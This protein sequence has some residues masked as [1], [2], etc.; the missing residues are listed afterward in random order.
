MCRQFLIGA[1]TLAIT[2]CGSGGQE[3]AVGTP[4]PSGADPTRIFAVQGNGPASPLVGQSVTVQGIVTGDFQDGD[5]DTTRDLGGFYMQDAPDG[6]FATSD[7]IFVFDGSNPPVD[8][9]AGDVVRVTGT[10]NEYYGETQIS[11]GNVTIVGT[12]SLLPVS[13][14]LPA[15][16]TVSNADGQLVADLER[17]EGMLVQFPQTLSVASLYSL[18]RDGDVLLSLDGVP[19]SFTNGNAPDV[20]GYA[21]HRSSIAARRVILD[22]G[23][24]AA[25]V[26]PVRYLGAG[27]TTGYSIRL[28]DQLSNARGVLR[29]SRGSGASGTEGYRLMP[30]ADLAF[31][32]VNPLPAAPEPGGTLRIAALNVLNLFSKLDDG[33]DQCGPDANQACR[34]ANSAAEL[35][36]QLARLVTAITLMEPDIIGVIEIENNANG[37]LD[38]LVSAL[39]ASLAPGTYAYVETGPIGTDAIKV[40][41][42]YRPSRVSPVGSPAIL[43]SAVDVRFDDRRNRPVLAQTFAQVSDDARLTVAI[44]HLKSKSSS[45]ASDGDP[46]IGDG[47]GNCNL[48]RTEAARAL[49]AW[50]AADPTGSGDPDTLLIGD[51]NAYVFEDP[52]AVLEAA[53]FVNLLKQGIGSGAYS[54]SFDGQRGVLDHALASASLAPQV[55]GAAEWHIN[56][57]EPPLLDYNLEVPRDPG[58]FDGSSP[59]RASDH[60]PLVVGINLAP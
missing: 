7:G 60:D 33:S 15:A 18:E 5:A 26:T 2:A 1:L 39:N 48:V 30:T 54:Y 47:Q 8:V 28:G 43:D 34:G 21:A 10:V 46:D 36:R 50:L 44:A 19:A 9:D 16:T 49:G 11:P 55:A 40:G 35:D 4:P 22:D 51:L 37:S 32:A 45:C 25:N 53:G 27:S 13:I 58:L 52:L 56:A 41:L 59:R 12:G 42:L 17:Y 14:S 6:D 24:K 20:A 29:Y 38:L 23:L 57:D 31:E 3:P